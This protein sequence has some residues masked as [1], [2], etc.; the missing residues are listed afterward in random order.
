LLERCRNERCE[1]APGDRSG[2][3][4]IDDEEGDFMTRQAS[5]PPPDN[6][7][8]SPPPEQSPP[9][10]RHVLLLVAL[11]LFLWLLLT[12]PVTTGPSPVSLSYS[13]FIHDVRAHD[14]ATFKV[15]SDGTATGTLKNGTSYTT[16]VPVELNDP[17]LVSE[18]QSGGAQITAN[19]PGPS[20]GTEILDWVLL[21]LVFVGPL[22]LWLWLS[23]RGG[24]SIQ[25]MLGVGKSNAKVFDS[26][27]PSTTFA[28]V[29][30]YDGPKREI[31]E[32]VTFLKNPERYKRAGA[33]APKGVLMVGPPGTGKT[34]LARAVAGEAGVPFFSVR[35]PRSSR[36]S[37]ASARR[38]CATCSTRPRRSPPRSSSSTRSTAS[39]RSAAGRWSPTTSA[40]RP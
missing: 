35:D 20:L 38:G 12:L 19:S 24:N 28:D 22:A 32:V 30:G 2:R 16:V 31:F 15:N 25:G 29:A 40:S 27:R 17:S 39:G 3:Q 13:Q 1:P 14:V 6:S 37:S 18:L 8:S 34:L 36:C 26:S 4:G 23:T 11:G 7:G 5:S 10:W 9:R 21:I 33:V